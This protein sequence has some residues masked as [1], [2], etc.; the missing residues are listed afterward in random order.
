M[1]SECC[2]ALSRF[3]PDLRLQRARRHAPCAHRSGADS[4]VLPPENQAALY[5][6]TQCLYCASE[7]GLVLLLEPWSNAGC[8]VER[9]QE[10]GNNFEN[11]GVVLVDVLLAYFHRNQ[12]ERKVFEVPESGAILLL[13]SLA[14]AS[15]SLLEGLAGAMNS[16]AGAVDSPGVL[17]VHRGSDFPSLTMRCLGILLGG[18]RLYSLGH[19]WDT[20]GCLS[21]PLGTLVA[22]LHLRLVE[23]HPIL[24]CRLWREMSNA[25]LVRGAETLHCLKSLI[26]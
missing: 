17:L 11:E 2:V 25:C 6:A 21:Y 23:V 26:A 8:A 9:N 4:L 13:Q 1:Q 5:S 7:L 24:Y 10:R 3:P 18:F 19:C 12:V 22:P 15:R 20:L 16:R 14:V